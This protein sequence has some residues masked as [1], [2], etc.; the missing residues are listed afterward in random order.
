MKLRNSTGYN[1]WQLRNGGGVAFLSSF[2]SSAF[3]S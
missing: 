2:I 3:G 1:M